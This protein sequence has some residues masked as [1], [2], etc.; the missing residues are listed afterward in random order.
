V[1]IATE[2]SE[3]GNIILLNKK[4]N[5]ILHKARIQDGTAIFC[6]ASDFEADLISVLAFPTLVHDITSMAEKWGNDG[7][8]GRINPF[9]EIYDVSFFSRRAFFGAEFMLFSSFSS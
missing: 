4:L 6:T 1:D 3:E 5:K 9:I 2:E 7:K 8:N